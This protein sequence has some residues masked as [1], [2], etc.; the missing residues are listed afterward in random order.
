VKEVGRVITSPEVREALHAFDSAVV[1][2]ALVPWLKRAGQQRGEAPSDP[3]RFWKMA[4]KA[5]SYVR[6]NAA[7]QIM[8]ANSTVLLEQ[9]THFPS[10]LVRLDAGR[11]ASGLWS[12]ATNHAEVAKM[13]HDASPYMATR[14]SAAMDAAKSSLDRILLDPSVTDTVGDWS[15]E[16]GRFLMA[17][18]QSVMDHA[19]WSAAFD[20]AMETMPSD[21]AVRHADAT[22]RELLGSYA[23]EDVSRIEAGTPLQRLFTMFYGFFNTKANV[24][25]TELTIAKQ[26]GLPES[27]SRVAAALLWGFLVPSMLGLG[28]KHAVAGKGALA[29]EDDEGSLHALLAFIGESGLEM[30]ARMV[31]F[32][33]SALM[34]AEKAFHAG[35]GDDLLNSPAIKMAQ[36]AITAPGHLARGAAGDGVTGKEITDLFTLLGMATGLPARPIGRALG[37]AHDVHAGRTQAATGMDYARGLTTGH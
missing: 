9:L 5:A 36:D 20:K 7:L 33:G 8:A 14:E 3:G 37:Y 1:G 23:P 2:D 27:K 35:R 15:R 24:L 18:I 25:K 30:G 6:E 34:A 21:E 10:V 31:P 22:V 11:V 29:Q 12:Y 28:I 16:H 17:G 19:T 32:G 13:I 4:N 26:V